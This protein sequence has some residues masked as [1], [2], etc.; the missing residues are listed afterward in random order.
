MKVYKFGGASVKDANS[1]KNMAAI[2]QAC[3]QP[4]V[5]VVSAMGKTTNAMEKLVTAYFD[6]KELVKSEA[7]HEIK[8]YH[9]TIV[10]ELFEENG[11]YKH[12]LEKWFDKLWNR[13]EQ[14]PSL[15][16]DFEYDQIVP[17]GELISTSIISAYLDYK[18]MQNKWTDIRQF[19]L[20]NDVYRDAG[21]EWELTTSFMKKF[22]SF[23]DT[24]LYITQGFI[25]GT[26]NNISTT[27]GREGSDYT[28]AIIGHVMEAENV[29][30]WKDVPGV[31]NAD[32]RWYHKTKKIDEL[33]YW[34]AIELAFYGAQVIHPKTLKPL[35]NKQIPLLVK[36]FVD[37]AS[38]G[39]CIREID[40]KLKLPPVYILKEEQLFI[41][42]S[43]RDFSFIMEESLS[44]IFSLFSH[45]RVKINLMQSSALNFSVCVNHH[46]NL[47]NIINELSEKYVVRYNDD[48]ELL[49]IR[50]YNDAAIEEMTNE[51]EIID[52]Q[53]S[54]KTARF[55]VRKSEWVFQN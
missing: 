2:V 45:F 23:T 21:V 7:F 50:H 22:F 32:P 4:L 41:T 13:L 46:R 17:Y 44:E 30:I 14:A 5:V 42:V 24:N 10:E 48:V 39:T 29:A 53:I 19:L 11:Y 52:S 40:G 27:L 8:N 16:F 6:R 26:V 9:Q 3:N 12:V 49:T 55:V 36:S 51:K 15:N 25:G 31:L 47:Q 34:E 35:Q 43:P 18:G 38:S 37:P 28:A 20:T 33:S 1:V 54:R